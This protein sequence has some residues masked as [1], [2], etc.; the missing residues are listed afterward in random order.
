MY[1]DKKSKLKVALIILLTVSQ[2]VMCITLL[3][4]DEVVK[5]IL[6]SVVIVMVIASLLVDRKLKINKKYN[7]TCSIINNMYI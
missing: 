3:L 1:N 5:I 2:I 4:I 6:L 7:V